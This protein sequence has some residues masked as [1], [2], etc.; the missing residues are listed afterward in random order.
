M[1]ILQEYLE[2]HMINTKN[3]MG[4]R[5]AELIFNIDESGPSDWED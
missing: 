1:I 5:L 4:G 2:T 3:S